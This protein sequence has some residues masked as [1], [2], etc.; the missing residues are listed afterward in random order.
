MTAGSQP[1]T[2]SAAINHHSPKVFTYPS[3]CTA[4][5]FGVFQTGFGGLVAYFF[6]QVGGSVRSILGGES[7]PGVY[8]E[9][10]PGSADDPADLF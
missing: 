8:G 9:D 1:S 10:Q 2:A 4:F 3:L 6:F 7:H 5:N